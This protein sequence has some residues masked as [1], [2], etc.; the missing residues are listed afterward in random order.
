M[1]TIQNRSADKSRTFSRRTALLVGAAT[2]TVAVG[3]VMGSGVGNAATAE[4][5]AAASK[6]QPSHFLSAKAGMAAKAGA[7]AKAATYPAR[8]PNLVVGTYQPDESTT[9]LLDGCTKEA[10]AVRNGDWIVTVPNTIITDTLINGR[11]IIRAANVQVTNCWIQGP[12]APTNA[13]QALVDCTHAAVKNFIIRDSVLAPQKPTYGW[14]AIAGHDYGAY[15]VNMYFCVDGG[16][17]YNGNTGMKDAATNV[18]ISGCWIHDLTLFTPDPNHRN[19]NR[20]HNDGIQI[21]GGAGTKIIGTR[22]DGFYATTWPGMVKATSD[23]TDPAVNVWA[24][25]HVYSASGRCIVTSCIQVTP[26]VGAVTGLILDRNYFNGGAVGVNAANGSPYAGLNGGK[27]GTF[28]GN[29]FDH[30][31]GI[32][33]GGGNKTFTI[34]YGAKYTLVQSG[35]IYGD[36]GAPVYVRANQ[37]V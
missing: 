33:G 32:Q 8:W 27:L 21:E 26:N 28:T 35:N 29:R 10:L 18:I 24:S 6:Q 4:K 20:T 13:N 19:D 23:P 22:I 5:F 7:V 17:I 1:I 34:A 3:F 2:S 30:K 15:R 9:G 12:V 25:P 37:T 36:N 11:L 16:R 14:N 31:Q